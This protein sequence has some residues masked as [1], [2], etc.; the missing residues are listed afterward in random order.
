MSHFGNSQ[1][2]TNGNNDPNNPW[3][4]FAT[5]NLGAS[6]GRSFIPPLSQFQTPQTSTP[7][8]SFPMSNMNSSNPNPFGFERAQPR[9]RQENQLTAPPGMDS[10]VFDALPDDLKK[11]CLRN[12]S[13]F[14]EGQI[15]ARDQVIE[16][17]ERDRWDG[18]SLQT[19]ETKLIR[20][21]IGMNN[22]KKTFRF[23]YVAVLKMV[24]KTSVMEGSMPS[25]L[26]SNFVIHFGHQI[27]NN[28]EEVSINPVSIFK[29]FEEQLCDTLI[30]YLYRL[31]PDSGMTLERM[32][33]WVPQLM[34]NFFESVKQIG[35][36]S[37]SDPNV[38][39]RFLNNVR[40]YIQNEFVSKV[41]GKMSP[42]FNSI[43]MPSNGML[44]STPKRVSTYIPNVSDFDPYTSN[45]YDEDPSEMR[46]K[47]RRIENDF[48][49]SNNSF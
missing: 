38:E 34:Y 44:G 4:N 32:M 31:G 6:M 18:P 9:S 15:K 46:V 33:K 35:A 2:S 11:E 21:E 27:D 7:T 19:R 16:N 17:L 28:I 37:H 47:F 5:R 10:E 25:E 43:A 14:I 23:N 36:L 30:V 42:I 1:D 12:P 22:S 20:P 26:I 40:E 3:A 41:E 39:A 8:T 49:E 48:N 29:I 45:S 13:Y 24:A